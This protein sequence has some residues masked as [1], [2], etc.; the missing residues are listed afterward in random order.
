MNLNIKNEG[1]WD[2][3]HSHGTGFKTAA[4]NLTGAVKSV[5]TGTPINTTNV[6]QQKVK[7]LYARFEKDVDKNLS[8]V[9]GNT[10]NV[11]N[12]IQSDINLKQ[13]FLEFLKDLGGCLVGA[14]GVHLN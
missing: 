6:Q 9:N 8:I 10:K 3:L 13:T 7:A 14:D 11:S 4:K 2:R 12:K 5:A 1:L